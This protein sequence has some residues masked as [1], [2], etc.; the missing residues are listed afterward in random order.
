M[1]TRSSSIWDLVP[2][3]EIEPGP[4]HWEHEIFATGL[5]GKSQAWRLLESFF[6]YM[7]VPQL[8]DSKGPTGAQTSLSFSLCLFLPLL[9]AVSP[10]SGFALVRL[11]SGEGNGTPLQY[12]CLETLMDGGAW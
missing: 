7:V 9:F 11:L 8:E 10:N 12:S 6:T 4:Q 2:G 5:P 1:Q 3:P